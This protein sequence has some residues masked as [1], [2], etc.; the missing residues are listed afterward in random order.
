[1]KF[2]CQ[3]C[4]AKYQISD[5]KVAGRTVK[6]KC[7]KCGTIIPIRAAPSTG[8][9]AAAPVVRAQSLRPHQPVSEAPIPA[10]AAEWHAGIGGASIGPLSKGEIE[11]RVADGS[12][13][14][15]TFVWREGMDGWEK[16]SEI[17]ELHSVL[18]TVG[19]AAPP[20]SMP[21]EAKRQPAPRPTRTAPGLI[22]TAP[23]P[24]KADPR[25]ERADAF[26]AKA[27]PQP[28]LL[29][30]QSRTENRPEA[31][32]ASDP[33]IT[34]IEAVLGIPSLLAPA[35]E[36]LTIPA[37]AAA[38]LA[39]VSV[40]VVPGA[41]VAVVPAIVPLAA[42]AGPESSVLAPPVAQPEVV[43]ASTFEAPVPEIATQGLAP[44]VPNRE[45]TSP[46]SEIPP[47]K[48]GR[49]SLA[50]PFAV[51]AAV[52]FG[53]TMGFVLFGGQKTKIIREVVE[54]PSTSAGET[55]PNS[56]VESGE[57]ITIPAED[58]AT[59]T[60]AEKSAGRGAGT[61][62]GSR[63]HTSKKVSPD[64]PKGLKGLS[65][66]AGLR[67]PNAGGPSL[68]GGR[69]SG[70]PLTSSQIQR[71]VSKYR[72]SVKRG[73]WERALMARDKNAPS[74]ARVTVAIKV[75]SSGSVRGAT[76]GG[77]PKGYRGLA[78]C[79]SR[80]VKGWKFPRSSGTT[81]VNVPF[82]FAAQ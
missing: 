38:P 33:L 18:A 45:S 20:P 50:V 48:A 23:R 64:A 37:P 3:N 51:L 73:C 9:M 78:S 22:K 29:A 17:P 47:V 1:M 67:G 49:S 16:I 15:E 70:P 13:T 68:S 59:E 53:V 56:Q 60:G 44:S 58:E 79:I 80:R 11:K 66:L 76:T 30:G 26:A 12:V 42:P 2:S 81:T 14:P 54:V 82:V 61:K 39:P 74:T 21:V 6:M 7:R 5:E 8:S 43:S 62:P 72:T 57:V 4:A 77:D 19:L 63:R 69:K 31:V 25:Q 65:G 32:T 71:T 55:S 24:T 36:Q 52:V 40:A 34:E 27:A 75:A 46:V 28:D 35:D 41:S 10:V